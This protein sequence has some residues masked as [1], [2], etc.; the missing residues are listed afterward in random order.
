M[1]LSD[2]SVLHAYRTLGTSADKI[3]AFPELRRVFLDRL[4]VEDDDGQAVWHLLK[5][6]KAGRLPKNSPLGS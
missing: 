3:A 1:I 2:D 5:L 4:A 6:G